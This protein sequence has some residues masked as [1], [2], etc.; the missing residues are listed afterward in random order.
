MRKTLFLSLLG[1]ALLFGGCIRQSAVTADASWRT[2][3]R[4]AFDAGQY[5]RARSL[6]KRAD[7]CDIPWTELS[8]RTL[9]LRI[10]LAEGTQNGEFRRLQ[11]AWTR[12]S[13][14]WTEAEVA[15]AEL[16]VAEALQP[17]FALDVLY[18]LDPHGWPA[19]LRSRYNL[20]FARHLRGAPRLYDVTL[21]KW[22]LGIRALYD[23]GD[24]EAAANEALRCA[25]AMRHAGTAFTAAKIFNELYRA[26]QKEAAVAL[27]LSYA[28]NS[29]EAVS[30][31]TLIR[32]SRLGTKS[33]L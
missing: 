11:Q 31:A 15:D 30:E 21:T 10:A 6:L 20:L 14:R 2:Q 16:T 24:R 3:A 22:T 28:N 9:E 25:Q 18:D 8:R 7:G 1:S 32:S 12:P 23:A 19:D 26:A 29:E 13:D 5:S 33:A 27:A 4:V 17:E